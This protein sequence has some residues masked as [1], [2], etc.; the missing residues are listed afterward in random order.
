[1]IFFDLEDYYK[2]EWLEQYDWEALG[3]SLRCCIER[4]ELPGGGIVIP[5]GPWDYNS[6]ITNRLYAEILVP[7]GPNMNVRAE[8]VPGFYRA[9][10]TFSKDP[11]RQKDRE[12][13]VENWTKGKE[14]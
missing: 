11:S 4:F 7:C 14:I 5:F 3:L 8:F 10:A 6:R 12:K 2:L 9:G 1:M 13:R